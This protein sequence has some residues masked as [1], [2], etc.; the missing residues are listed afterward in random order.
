LAVA[1]EVRLDRDG[2]LAG[3]LYLEECEGARTAGDDRAGGAA[4]ERGGE[5]GAA[6][7]EDRASRGIRVRHGRLIVGLLDRPGA[8]D[9]ERFAPVGG[10]GERPRV[11]GADATPDDLGGLAPVD[12]AVRPRELR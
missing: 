3:A 4:G 8:M 12:C 1:V 7:R 6:A 11:E 9:E 2:A 5:L 10:G